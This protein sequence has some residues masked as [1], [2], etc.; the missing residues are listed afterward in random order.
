MS[1][2]GVISP[3]W[4]QLRVQNNQVYWEIHAKCLIREGSN[5]SWFGVTFVP[6]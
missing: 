6:F 2:R 4:W 1:K 3:T 5:G